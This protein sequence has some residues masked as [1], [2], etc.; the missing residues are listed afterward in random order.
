MRPFLCSLLV[1]AACHVPPP[2]PVT[3]CTDDVA[4]TIK[5]MKAEPFASRVD[6]RYGS[7]LYSW[8]TETPTE[9]KY[10]HLSTQ[11]TRAGCSVHFTYQT[12]KK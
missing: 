4:Q 1:L 2:T 10:T 5:I 3:T 9:L 6:D 11:Q 12:F 7:G 8:R